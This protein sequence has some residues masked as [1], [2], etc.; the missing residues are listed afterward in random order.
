MENY[1]MKARKNKRRIDPRYH[2][3]ET[4]EQI[5]EESNAV[6]QD[7]MKR[8]MKDYHDFSFDSWLNE[9]RIEG[10]ASVE[11]PDKKDEED[12]FDY[13]KGKKVAGDKVFEESEAL[14]EITID[15]RSPNVG[16]DDEEMEEFPGGTVADLPDEVVD[17]QTSSCGAG[18]EDKLYFVD[19]GLLGKLEARNLKGAVDFALHALKNDLEIADMSAEVAAAVQGLSESDDLEEG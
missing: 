2:L 14:E 19:L 11:A 18:K 7:K 8:H 3:D 12:D 5:E 10:D 9:G 15:M 6:R 13:L 4:I 17:V 1:A 16:E